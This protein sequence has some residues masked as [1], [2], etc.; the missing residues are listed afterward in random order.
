MELGIQWYEAVTFTQLMGNF[1]G[2]FFLSLIFLFSSKKTLLIMLLVIWPVT[3][4]TVYSFSLENLD[5]LSEINE[6]SLSIYKSAEQF[7][8]FPRKE[9]EHTFNEIAR[10]QK[11]GFQYGGALLNSPQI[12]KLD[13]SSFL[14][15]NELT[16]YAKFID[17]CYS[18]ELVTAIW[19]TRLSGYPVHQNEA[20]RAL[21]YAEARTDSVKPECLGTTASLSF[22]E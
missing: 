14:S 10:V 7:P 19:N 20:K 21:T 16:V 9:V 1:F 17:H 8:L 13:G 11:D 2:A 22:L 5:R 18:P 4:L 12:Y 3:G 15:D 6:K